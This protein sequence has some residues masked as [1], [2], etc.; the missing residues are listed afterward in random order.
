LRSAGGSS[1]K[2]VSSI[3]S[4]VLFL[5]VLSFSQA[6]DE[7]G[8]K[9]YGSY[10]G[11][12]IDIVNLNNSKLELHIPLLS[13]PQRGRLQLNFE[14]TYQS[15]MWDETKSCVPNQI[16]IFLSGYDRNRSQWNLRHEN[17]RE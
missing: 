10:H 1:V 5:S 9:P 7:Q 16:R 2:A 13:Y 12:D 3:V 17:C 11:G 6:I 15:E 8:V 14:L 4:F